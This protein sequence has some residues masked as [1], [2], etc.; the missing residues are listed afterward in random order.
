MPHIVF[1]N[2]QESLILFDYLNVDTVLFCQI[3]LTNRTVMPRL[4]RT[5]I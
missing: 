4:L 5:E 1:F 2:A 3:V